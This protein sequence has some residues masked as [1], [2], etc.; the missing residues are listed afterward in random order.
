MP[1][2]KNK[3]Q[4]VLTLTSGRSGT[5][6]LAAKLKK[7]TRAVVLHEP[8]PDFCDA[9]RS[10]I[11]DLDA[12]RQFVRAHK[13]PAIQSHWPRDYVETSHLAAKGFV[14]P[15]LLEGIRL[16]AIVLR[17]DPI[18]VALSLQAIG[19][20][21]GKSDLGNRYLSLPSDINSLPISEWESL[22]DLQRCMW[23][24]LDSNQRAQ[25]CAD[26][27]TEFG[28][29]VRT[30][31]FTQIPQTLSVMQIARQLQ[32]KL[33][34]PVT[35]FS[36]VWGQKNRKA[37]SRKELDVT[38]QEAAAQFDRVVQLTEHAKA[39]KA[40]AAERSARDFLKS[41]FGV[42][43]VRSFIPSDDLRHIC[44]TYAKYVLNV[45]TA[46]MAASLETSLLLFALHMAQ[47]PEVCVDL[48]SGFSSFVLRYAAQKHGGAVISVD[49]SA[50]WLGR[51]GRFLNEC[52]LASD[53]LLEFERFRSSTKESFPLVFHDLGSFATR[54]ESLEFVTKL[55]ADGGVLIL[56]DA[57]RE[58]LRH[59]ANYV[60]GGRNESI[61]DFRSLSSDSYGRYPWI[62]GD[63]VSAELSSP[64][65]LDIPDA[66]SVLA[67]NLGS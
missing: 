25:E 56:D 17:R 34:F 5:N 49:D 11:N 26:L 44:E 18:D 13:L 53:N 14:L 60:V 37:D 19:T 40:L 43:D 57:H 51:T 36:P 63:G 29:I 8:A 47:K 48:G 6:Y 28:G 10:A 7:A 62:V 42:T 66:A 59:A 1:E 35:A 61:Y 39:M 32:L 3:S 9:M 52:G 58:A 24:A 2:P 4:V 50:E 27:I 16:N 46:N 65:A 31:D 67:A 54:I 21:P 20:V 23:Y 45:S 55:R 41:G 12:G 30:L 15:L 38:R 22:T 64:E 33:A